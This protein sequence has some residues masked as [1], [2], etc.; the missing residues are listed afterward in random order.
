E[1][2][3]IGREQRAQLV[4]L[5]G[6][7]ADDGGGEPVERGGRR[8]LAGEAGVEADERLVETAGG[9]RERAGRGGDTG[10]LGGERG[11]RLALARVARAAGGVE[12]LRHEVR[13]R[14]EHLALRVL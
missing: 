11:Q 7:R 6:E 3:A 5:L 4:Q 2:H 1:G 10:G 13:R 12:L 9:G 8:R 14:L